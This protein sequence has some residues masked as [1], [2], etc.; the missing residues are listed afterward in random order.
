M[1]IL[2]KE[3]VNETINNKETKENY[4]AIK[5]NYND[6]KNQYD[7]LNI[8]YQTLSDENFNFRRDKMLYEQE[9]NTKNLMIEDLLH[10]NSNIRQRE[11]KERISKLKLNEIEVPHIDKNLIEKENLGEKNDSQNLDKKNLDNKN[12]DKKNLEEKKVDE[13]NLDKKEDQ[14]INKDSNN[15]EIIINKAP[16]EGIRKIDELGLEEL[17]N[18]REEIMR[19]RKNATNEYYKIPNKANKEQIK[20][21]NK[22]EIKLDQINNDLAKIRIRMNILKNS[23]KH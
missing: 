7:L 17:I 1:I 22:L 15:E 13:K 3:Y 5:N 9:I 21:R 11:L 23:K 19:N 16:H 4:N 18:K 12:L 20:K 8:K 10:S 2:K 6:I 14:N